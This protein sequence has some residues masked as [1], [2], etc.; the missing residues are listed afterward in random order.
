MR[1]YEAIMLHPTY[2]KEVLI[3]FGFGEVSPLRVERWFRIEYP[4]TYKRIKSNLKYFNE[5]V[6]EATNM[7][8][9]KTEATTREER[10]AILDIA[11]DNIEKEKHDLL[12]KL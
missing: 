2:K 3:E 8:P 12:D 5:V 10:S 9:I 1:I 6:G 7:I 11:M 4:M